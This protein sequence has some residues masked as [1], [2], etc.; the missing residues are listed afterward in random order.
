MA[1]SAS[2][3]SN[4]RAI[5]GC[6]GRDATKLRAEKYK[7]IRRY[8]IPQDLL[9]GTLTQTY[10]R[11]GKPGCHCY[12][13]DGHPMWVLTYS[14]DGQRIVEFVPSAL[15]DELAELCEQGA[16]YAH[17]VKRV[18]AINAQLFSLYKQAQK[19]KSSGQRKK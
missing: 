7:L 10:R 3:T 6:R 15:V 4:R 16:E 2:N 12:V 14:V 8:G 5:F 13:S 9:G 17:A 19:K 1:N 18:R 11:C